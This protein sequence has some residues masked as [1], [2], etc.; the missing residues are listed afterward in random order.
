MDWDK[1][2]AYSYNS[3]ANP[4]RI[5]GGRAA[6]TDSYDLHKTSDGISLRL[7]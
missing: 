5:A 1:S 2:V 6:I 4:N 3:E 7:S